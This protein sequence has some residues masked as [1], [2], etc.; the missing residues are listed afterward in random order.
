MHGYCTYELIFGILPRQFVDFNKIDRVE[1]LYN[2]ED[3]SKEIK[4]RL[5]T[6]YNRARLMLE[7]AKAYRKQNYDKKT[8]DFKFKKGDKVTPR[9]EAAH[10]LD[11]VYLG[12][13]MVETI[14]DRDNIIIG[15]KKQKK[16]KVHKDRL[17][18]CNQ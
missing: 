16:Q 15:N 18:I 2:V 17:K 4:F 14:E 3:Y 8:S 13:Y 5:E 12:P 9:N 1:P 7:K 6:A 10:K 11:P